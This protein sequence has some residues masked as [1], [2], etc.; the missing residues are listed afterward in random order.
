MTEP[1]LF[2][3]IRARVAEPTL[4]IDMTTVP[5][6]PRYEPASAAALAEA[7]VSLSFQLPPSLRRLYAEVAN[8]GFGPGAG[9]VGV[10]GGHADVNGR[11]LVSSYAAM[12]VD[13][14]PERLLPLWDLGCGAWSCLEARATDGHLITIDETGPTQTPFTLSSWLEAW[15]KGAEML[16]E[17]Y[18]L[19]DG[20][21]VNPFTQKPMAI[22][23][24]G[25]AKGVPIRLI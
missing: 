18:E 14:W 22:K 2:E 6:P 1:E 13:G 24:R 20:I 12:R 16:N 8:G 4:R 7:E 15:L 5:T 25:R 21:L 19:E 23:R 9:L 11:T 3:A 17:T 10:R